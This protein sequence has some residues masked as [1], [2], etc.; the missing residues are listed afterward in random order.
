MNKYYLS[1]SLW[2]ALWLGIG[3]AYAD[4]GGLRRL[5]QVQAQAKAR[6][7]RQSLKTKSTQLVV[8]DTA[9]LTVKD[10]AKKQNKTQLPVK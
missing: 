7:I 2:M 6:E 3:S 5:E 10:Q 4:D 9:S 8:A 1:Y